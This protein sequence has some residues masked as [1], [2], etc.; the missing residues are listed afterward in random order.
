MKNISMFCLTLNPSHEEIIKDLSY[1]PVGLGENK[2]SSNCF[3]DKIGVYIAHK[4]PYYGEYTII[5][6]GKS[7]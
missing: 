3:S 6:F 7:I 4:N 5:G 2:F 1:M